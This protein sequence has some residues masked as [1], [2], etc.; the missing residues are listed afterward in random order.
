MAPYK[1]FVSR[2]IMT[3][4][5]PQFSLSQPKHDQS[6]YWG[7]ARHFFITT[8]PLNILATQEQLEEAKELLDMFK[9]GEAE[10]V[11]EDELWKA[12][13]LYESAYHPDTGRFHRGSLHSLNL[14]S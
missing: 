13:Q 4:L 7:R 2:S 11:G 8:N 3:L 12:K 10:N 5:Q 14:Y 6:T 1:L 9:K